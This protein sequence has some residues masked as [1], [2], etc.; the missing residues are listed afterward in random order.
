M[1]VSQAASVF[2]GCH[3]EKS[4]R[5][6]KDKEN[7]V[8]RI[9]FKFL[10]NLGTWSSIF[11]SRPILH[12]RYCGRLGVWCLCFFGFL[13]AFFLWLFYAVVYFLHTLGTLLW[14]LFNE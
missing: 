11:V 4:N 13:L 12:Y 10:Y 8:H 7:F 14:I 2:S 1:K 3:G 6:F 9:K 5:A